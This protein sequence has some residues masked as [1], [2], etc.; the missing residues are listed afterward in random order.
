MYCGESGHFLRECPKKERDLADGRIK[1][2]ENRR[3]LRFPDGTNIPSGEGP[4][5]SRV[6]R[7]HKSRAVNILSEYDEEIPIYDEIKPPA[8]YSTY[9]CKI[10]D[11]RDDHIDTQ[12]DIIRRKER[13]LEESR[14]ALD[15]Y[16]QVSNP[17]SSTP[18]SQV[19]SQL[20]VQETKQS[21][22][23]KEE[24]DFLKA[25]MKHLLLSGN[26]PST[27]QGF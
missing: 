15:T 8:R 21:T 1:W 19:A 20:P 17:Q 27:Q 6:D 3:Y 23:L 26:T 7:Y 10:R 16:K 5:S 22:E 4:I 9:V 24:L 13:E 2:D 12:M 14:K 18:T 25:Q 11:T